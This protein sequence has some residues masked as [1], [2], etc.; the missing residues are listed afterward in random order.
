MRIG[1]EGVAAFKPIGT[2]GEENI[3]CNKCRKKLDGFYSG[4]TNS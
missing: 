1:T 2:I 3:Q 4:R